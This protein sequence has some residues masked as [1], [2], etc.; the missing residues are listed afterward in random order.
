MAAGGS[1]TNTLNRSLLRQF[2]VHAFQY[3]LDP[4]GANLAFITSK[5]CKALFRMEY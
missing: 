1:S 2:L 4:H 3:F 5:G